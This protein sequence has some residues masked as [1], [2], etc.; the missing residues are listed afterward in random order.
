MTAHKTGVLARL[1][2]RMV[3]AVLE[4]NDKETELL[5]KFV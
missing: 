4:I 2:C 5:V 1:S 3:C